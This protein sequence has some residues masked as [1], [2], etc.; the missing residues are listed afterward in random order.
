MKLS[1]I[2]SILKENGEKEVLLNEVRKGK[3]EYEIKNYPNLKFGVSFHNNGL[4]VNT[5]FNRCIIRREEY[6]GISKEKIIFKEGSYGYNT[7]TILS[8]VFG[9]YSEK[10]I[11]INIDKIKKF[12]NY[13]EAYNGFIITLNNDVKIYVEYVD[14]SVEEEE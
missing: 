11:E 10:R 13:E 14:V 3:I 4:Y 9:E 7:T 2:I 6:L 5:E 1:D 12:K 8:N